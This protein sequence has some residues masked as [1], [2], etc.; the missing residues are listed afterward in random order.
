MMFYPLALDGTELTVLGAR[1][2][3]AELEAERALALR[4]EL[5]A[6]E[7]FMADLDAELVFCRQVYAVLA[8]TE[9]ASLRA[10]L[11]GSQTG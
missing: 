3:V 1:A 6:N 9:I 8:I 10:E 5:G 11:S 2:R 4:S 7:S